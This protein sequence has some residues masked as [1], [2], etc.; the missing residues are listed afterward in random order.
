MR[1][2]LLSITFQVVAPGHSFSLFALS[3]LSI[4]SGDDLPCRSKFWYVTNSFQLLRSSPSRM[5]S[6]I[7]DRFLS[8]LYAGF[9]SEPNLK[10]KTSGRCL[11]MTP[12]ADSKRN[13]KAR[14]VFERFNVRLR[15]REPNP[16]LVSGRPTTVAT[17]VIGT[18][19]LGRGLLGLCLVTLFMVS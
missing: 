4:S 9:H 8:E 14:T 12:A 17:F 16:M 11:A 7:S 2:S 19:L 6:I 5:N 13:Q 10:P 3:L 1:L 18:T 15:Y